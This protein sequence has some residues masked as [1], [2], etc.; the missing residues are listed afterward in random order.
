MV[1][2]RNNRQ[3]AIRD[4][5]RGQSIRTQKALVDQL[6]ALGFNCT[7]ATVSRDIADMGLRKLQE[8]IYVL[9]EDLHLQRMV[10]EF[11]TNIDQA[12]N[13]IVIHSQPGTAPGVAAAVDAASLPEIKGSV[14]GNDTVLVVADDMEAAEDFVSLINKL[15]NSTL[16]K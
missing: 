13:L 16:M 12:G 6:Q 7:Q 8:G 5:V 4:V 3:D 15:R 14:A 2:R 1:K 10:S 9:A 11:V